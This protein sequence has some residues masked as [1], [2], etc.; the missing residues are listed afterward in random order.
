MERLSRLF[1]RGRRLRTDALP[2]FLLLHALGGMKS[3]RRRTLRHRREVEHREAWLA[4]ALGQLPD[5]GL[6]VEVLRC[7]RLIKGYSDTHARGL[8]KFDRVLSALPLLRGR[9]DA[10]DWLRRLREAAL[11]DEAGKALDDALRTVR[12]F[13]GSPTLH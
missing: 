2:S 6:A 9:E 1:A 13:S 10:A 12:S 4:L 3:W 5:Y 7:R 11:K 8:S